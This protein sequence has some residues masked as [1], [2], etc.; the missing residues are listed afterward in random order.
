MV[1]VRR[2]GGI[3]L[4]A[5]VFTSYSSKIVGD[6]ACAACGRDVTEITFRR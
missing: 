1:G 2:V 4:G 3:V 5:D 6:A